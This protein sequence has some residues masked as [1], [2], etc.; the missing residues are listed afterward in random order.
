[1]INQIKVIFNPAKNNDRKSILYARALNKSGVEEMDLSKAC[2][3]KRYI[4]IILKKSTKNLKE[5]LNRKHVLVK[6][7]AVHQIKNN[8]ELIQLIISNI[9]LLRTPI[10]L[11]D[12]GVFIPNSSCDFIKLDHA[13]REIEKETNSKKLKT[14]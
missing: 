10:V 12:V 7:G 3:T 1:M 11:T 13:C 5:I 9:S 2:L 4:R 14:K 8:E 6:S